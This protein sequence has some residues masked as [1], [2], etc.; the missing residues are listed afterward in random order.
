MI[1][2]YLYLLSSFSSVVCL[3]LVSVAVNMLCTEQFWSEFFT[4]LSSKSR[5]GAALV[6]VTSALS[7]LAP[8]Q[9]I[10]YVAVNMSCTEQFWNEFFTTLSSKS[11]DGAALVYVTSAL[12]Q[13]APIRHIDCVD[14]FRYLKLYVHF[15]HNTL[16]YILYHQ[17]VDCRRDV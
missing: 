9:L 10:Y 14:A 4:T 17:C 11:R 7:Q 5:D 2:L 12:A 8:F 15:S 1:I 6:Y 16:C 13:L 3:C